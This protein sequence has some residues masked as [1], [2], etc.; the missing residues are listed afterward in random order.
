M[1]WSL[2]HSVPMTE[3][4]LNKTPNP[5]LTHWQEFDWQPIWPILRPNPPFYPTNKLVLCYL[6]ECYRMLSNA[7]L[8]SKVG[9]GISSKSPSHA[10]RWSNYAISCSLSQANHLQ[11]WMGYCIAGQGTMALCSKCCSIWKQVMDGGGVN[12][13]ILSYGLIGR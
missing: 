12:L 11:L 4:P 10:F 13:Q 1:I 8:V 6:I 3:V 7:H 5:Q 2:P 9:T